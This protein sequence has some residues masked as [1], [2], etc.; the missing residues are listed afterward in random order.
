MFLGRTFATVVSDTHVRK[1]LRMTTA[2]V[3]RAASAD[4]T[5]IAGQVLGDGPPLVLV[6]GGPHDGDVAWY[7]LVSHLSGRFT[8]YLPSVR[9][10]GLSADHPDHSPPRLEEDIAAFV[11]SVGEQVGVV[12][13]S[14]GAPNAFGAA[15]RTDAVAAIAIHEPTVLSVMSEADLA[16]LFATFERV[17]AAATE[18]RLVDAMKDFHAMFASDDESASFD[19][20]YFER[21]ADVVAPL[22]RQVQDSVGYDGPRSTDPDVLAMIDVPVLLLRGERTELSTFYSDAERYVAQHLGAPPEQVVLGGVGHFAPLLAPDAVAGKL[23][24]FLEAAW[25]P[26][27][28]SRG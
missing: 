3:H 22:L 7:R 16:Q 9:G 24:S 28:R 12:A 4:G 27:V 23:I 10:R 20:D 14:I 13:W 6:H 18:G 25:E 21:C 19:P 8:C 15:V 17:G 26:A 5:E 11:D 1:D 2:R